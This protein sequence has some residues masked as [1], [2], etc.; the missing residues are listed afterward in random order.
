MFVDQVIVMVCNF[1]IIN[2]FK[3]FFYEIEKFVID[4]L[5]GF[6]KDIILKFPRL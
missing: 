6:I 1:I 2:I 3:T 5:I 4:T